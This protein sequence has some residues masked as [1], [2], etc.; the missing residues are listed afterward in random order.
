MPAS[1]PEKDSGCYSGGCSESRAPCL[2]YVENTGLGSQSLVNNFNRLDR[3]CEEDRVQETSNC[4][5]ST[6]LLPY[7]M[8]KL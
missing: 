7:Q 2:S 8:G 3:L 5:V 4:P 1:M 6:K